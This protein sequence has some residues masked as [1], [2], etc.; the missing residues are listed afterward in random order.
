MQ[1]EQEEHSPWK[2]F[3]QSMPQIDDASQ[4]FFCDWPPDLLNE[5]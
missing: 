5:C 1:Q 2:E 3:I 4:L